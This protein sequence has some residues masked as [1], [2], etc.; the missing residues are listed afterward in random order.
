M[1]ERRKEKSATGGKEKRAQMISIRL[2]RVEERK[3]YPTMGRRE[4][5]IG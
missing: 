1:C 2:Q 3:L 5:T 4:K